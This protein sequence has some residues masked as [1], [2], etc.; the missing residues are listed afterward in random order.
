MIQQ[1]LWAPEQLISRKEAAKRI[2]VSLVTIDRAL[3]NNRLTRYRS[4]NGFHIR[5]DAREVDA[6]SAWTPET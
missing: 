4:G 1:A 3:A 6:L 2:K 5:L